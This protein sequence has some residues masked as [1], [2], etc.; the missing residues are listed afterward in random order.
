ML[1]N[2]VIVLG[3]SGG[4]AAYKAADLASKLAQA[5]A[6]VKL[7]MT[8]EATQLVQPL[9]FQALT[10]NP[11]V[12][13]MF[14]PAPLS[15]ITHVS[16]ADE[17][18]IVVIVP[19]TA[20]VIAKMAA[21]IADDILTC[22][23]LATKAPVVISP[24]MHH[25][26]YVNPVTQENIGK[27]KARGFTVIPAV[28]GRLASGSIG[29]GRLPEIPEIMGVIQQTLGKNSDL[30]GKRVVVTA[31]GT[32]EAI[33]PVRYITNNSSGKMGYAL[34]EA[35]RDR[36]A[37]VT[38]ITTPTGLNPVAGVE[39]VNVRSAREMK[40]AVVKAVAKT[41][42]LIMAAAVAD[43][44]PKTVAAQKI[45][46]G[47]GGMTLELV[48]TPDILSAVKGNFAKVGFAAETQD[49]IANAKKKLVN[50]SLDIIVANDVTVKDSGF[51]AETNKVTILKKDGKMEDLPLMSKREVAEKILDNVAKLLKARK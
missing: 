36:G 22:T 9:T 11:V 38:L 12:T 30:A 51:G 46:K 28:H 34:A 23:V 33:D 1:K 2:K 44:A 45:K 15:A 8:W 49:L 21:G 16:L 37:A 40:D 39:M 14:E 5:G 29:Y 48:K 31:G 27:L 42:A 18:D 20:N 3:I 35:A 10:G 41:D 32:Q 43:Y 26:M 4:I 50:K 6:T 47:T 13:D 25:N 7:V 24:A 19:A 17:A